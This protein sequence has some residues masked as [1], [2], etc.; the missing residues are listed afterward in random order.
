MWLTVSFS[1]VALIFAD[2]QMFSGIRI[3]LIGV[4]LIEDGKGLRN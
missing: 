4:M 3:D 2:F 1:S